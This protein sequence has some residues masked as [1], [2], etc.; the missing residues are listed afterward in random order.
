MAPDSTERKTSTFVEVRSWLAIVISVLAAGFSGWQAWTTTLRPA[1]IQGDLSYLVVWRFSSNKDGI[2]TDVALTPAFWLQ[3]VGA[4]P[5]IV[6]DL[7]MVL[8]PKDPPERTAIFPV[9]SVPLAA[10]EA[11]SEFNEYGRISSG[12]PFRSFSLTSSQLWVSAYKFGIPSDSLRK[13]VGDVGVKVAVRTSDSLEW[14]CVLNDSLD[15][16]PPAAD[17]GRGT[18]NPG[19]HAQVEYSDREVKGPRNF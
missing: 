2:V 9:S 10:I 12:S 17:D 8:T 3:N 5:V 18:I 14:I 16:L 7:R 4:R 15:F 13:L 6:Q 19:I 1:R 11:S